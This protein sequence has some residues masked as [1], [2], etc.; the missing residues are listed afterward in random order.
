VKLLNIAQNAEALEVMQFAC[1]PLYMHNVHITFTKVADFL[2]S[3]Q[4]LASLALVTDIGDKLRK[5]SWEL[6]PAPNTNSLLSDLPSRSSYFSSSSFHPSLPRFIS[7]FT[8]PYS[9]S[10]DF[11]KKNRGGK[12]PPSSSFP[13]HPPLYNR[14][15]RKYKP[16]KILN[17]QMHVGEFKRIWDTEFN[18]LMHQV[19]CR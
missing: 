17:F 9:H 2:I 12:I 5:N 19:S 14:V 3:S 10:A 7:F 1:R 6:A 16:S 8:I 18:T 13:S 4:F 11:L 15:V